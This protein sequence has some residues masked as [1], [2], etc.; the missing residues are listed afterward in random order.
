LKAA[1]QIISAEYQQ[2]TGTSR[3]TATRDLYDLVKKKVV[4]SH[5]RGRGAHYLAAQKMPH[6]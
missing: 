2:L 6:K 1:G 3:Q 4:V 5:G